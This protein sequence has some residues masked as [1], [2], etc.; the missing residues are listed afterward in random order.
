[1][2]NTSRVKR[3]ALWN[4]IYEVLARLDIKKV[5]GDSLDRPSAATEI[6]KLFKQKEQIE[7]V[8]I[9]KYQAEEIAYTL[10]LVA[11]HLRDQRT[12]LNENT[13]PSS[14]ERHTVK[15]WTWLKDIL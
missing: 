4:N 3:S 11:N 13:T 1:M 14:L 12:K 15:G 10:R 5:E 7:M 9:P 2:E 6:E 8:S